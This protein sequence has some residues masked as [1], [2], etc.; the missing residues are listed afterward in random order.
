MLVDNMI[1]HV[2]ERL[3]DQALTSGHGSPVPYLTYDKEVGKEPAWLSFI[4]QSGRCNAAGMGKNLHDSGH[5][6]EDQA[7]I[8]LI[9]PGSDCCHNLH[10]YSCCH[11]A[12]F[13]CTLQAATVCSMTSRGCN[14]CLST[15]HLQHMLGYGLLNMPCGTASC[16]DQP[17]RCRMSAMYPD[18]IE[19]P[20]YLLSEL[21]NEDQT[22]NEDVGICNVLLKLLIVLA[23]PQLF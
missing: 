1:P 14:M 21:L 9:S 23:V 2:I 22:A 4:L 10:Q 17:S 7:C 12:V 6:W 15:E 18:D 13:A 16:D 3:P 5:G 8:Q 11:N 20:A 19:W